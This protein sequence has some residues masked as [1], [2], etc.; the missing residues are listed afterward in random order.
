MRAWASAVSRS[1][2][3]APRMRGC[4]SKNPCALLHLFARCTPQSMLASHA[5]AT[6]ACGHLTKRCTLFIYS[7]A[8]HTA[9]LA[10]NHHQHEV[11]EAPRKS[12]PAHHS[13]APQI[14]GLRGWAAP[15][16]AGEPWASPPPPA[17]PPPLESA[18]P[19]PA[20]PRAPQTR[21]F[22]AA[23]AAKRSKAVTVA[24]CTGT[25]LV[26]THSAPSAAAR[27]RGP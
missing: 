9:P 23:R 10:A 26:N 14:L 2:E 21:P 15:P 7:S 5:A 12:I 13:A 8:G 1:R 27:S 17:P 6:Y 18:H 20:Q 4:F 19:A 22:I 25:E 3:Y 24:T 11:R 16:C